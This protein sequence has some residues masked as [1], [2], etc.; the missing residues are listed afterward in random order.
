MKSL[1]EALLLYVIP[2]S[3]LGAPLSLEKQ[4]ELALQGGASAIQLRDKRMDGKTLFATATRM[5]ALCR[6]Y[7][8]LFLVN[9]RLDIALACGADGVHLGQSDLP[10]NQARNLAKRPFIIG[11]SAGSVDEAQQA[12]EAGADYLG[13]GAVF[14]TASKQDIEVIG[15]TTLNLLANATQLPSVAIGGINHENL[16]QV[17]AQGVNGIAV[18]SA[19][20]TGNV[21]EQTARLLAQLTANG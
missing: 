4:T 14:A 13:F 9:D 19:A 7:G 10:I 18:I 1:A 20:I 8:A 5:Q 15:L 12:A 11:A 6:A 2:D 3:T 17:M 16:A 21:P